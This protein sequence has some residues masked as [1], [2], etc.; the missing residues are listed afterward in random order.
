MP[1]QLALGGECM[2]KLFVHYDKEGVP[3]AVADSK[4]ELAQITGIPLNTIYNGFWRKS[5]FYAEVDDDG[6]EEK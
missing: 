1:A 3:D 6:E 2:G 5:K 4:I